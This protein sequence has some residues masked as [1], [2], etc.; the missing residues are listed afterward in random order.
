MELLEALSR[1]WL[2]SQTP[3]E[4]GCDLEKIRLLRRVAVEVPNAAEQM[5]EP[6]REL[7]SEVFL[8]DASAV[9]AG[10]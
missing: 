7:Y 6:L 8:K 10:N 5:S 2:E 9:A 4:I 1:Q 3:I